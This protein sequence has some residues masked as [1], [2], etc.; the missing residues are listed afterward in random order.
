MVDSN[1]GVLDSTTEVIPELV[2]V[3]SDAEVF[4]RT[5]G[6]AP[7]RGRILAESRLALDK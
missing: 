2:V 7:S 3:R 4:H 6:E 1:R 5:Q